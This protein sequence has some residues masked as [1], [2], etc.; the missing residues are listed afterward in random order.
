MLDAVSAPAQKKSPVGGSEGE[1]WETFFLFFFGFEL[2]RGFSE[3]AGRGSYHERPWQYLC[4]RRALADTCYVGTYVNS[5][6]T[7]SQSPTLKGSG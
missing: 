6:S 3:V 7:S 2:Q 5:R 4:F 1:S